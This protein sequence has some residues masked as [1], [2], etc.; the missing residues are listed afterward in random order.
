MQRAYLLVMLVN[1]PLST[2][3]V[4]ARGGSNDLHIGHCELIERRVATR[5]A[6]VYDI[7]SSDA[8]SVNPSLHGYRD[9]AVCWK[10]LGGKFSCRLLLLVKTRI[11]G[12]CMVTCQRHAGFIRF[13]VD[14]LLLRCPPPPPPPPLST[15][16]HTHTHTNTQFYLY[17]FPLQSFSS[18][19][20]LPVLFAVVLVLVMLSPFLS[21]SLSVCLS[22][23]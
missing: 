16:R 7:P 6:L 23:S 11:R 17:V 8:R 12:H 20:P 9:C 5:Q 13:R 18:P 22:L 3:P 2:L 1:D 4:S 10:R 21:L 14:V 15:T 19:S